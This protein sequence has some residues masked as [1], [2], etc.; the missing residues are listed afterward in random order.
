MSV[1]SVPPVTGSPLMP[2]CATGQAP[3]LA[4]AVSSPSAIRASTPLD[5]EPTTGVGFTRAGRVAIATTG[6]APLGAPT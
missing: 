4:V 6:I 3:A 5:T 2:A 1:A